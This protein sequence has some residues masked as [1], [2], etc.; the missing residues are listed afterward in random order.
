MELE[1]L[2]KMIADVLGLDAESI[3]EDMSFK[4]DL[5]ADSLDLFEIIEAIGDEFEISIP[6]EEVESI[7]TVGDA[8][9]QI[10]R[11]VEEK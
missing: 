5:D 11:A 4:D 2:Q 3:T 10:K 9:E 1:K 7:E 6:T 8:L